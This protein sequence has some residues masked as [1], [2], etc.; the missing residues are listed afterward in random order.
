MKDVKITLLERMSEEKLC[1]DV[2]GGYDMYANA[3]RVFEM[4]GVT[5]EFRQLSEFESSWN[6]YDVKHGV[7]RKMKIDN[8][9]K[10]RGILRSD[11]QK[12]IRNKIPNENVKCGCN[13]TGVKVMGNRVDVEWANRETGEKG[14][15]SCD[16]LVGGDG[17]HSAVRTHVFPELP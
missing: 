5:R 9:I 14:F 1:G 15:E 11:I 3:E 16:L 7:I 12:I 4:L 2:G 8:N 17:V 6:F 13:V 10:L